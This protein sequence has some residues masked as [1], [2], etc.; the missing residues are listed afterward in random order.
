VSRGVPVWRCSVCGHAVFPARVLCLRCGGDEWESREV[1]EGVV[2]EATLVRRAP[3]GSLPVPVAVGS[4]RLEGD[5][6]V[7]ARLEPGMEEGRSIRLEYR[8][9]VPVATTTEP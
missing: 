4:V 3:G 7:V 2:D 5:V 9:G 8:D 6:L 1:D